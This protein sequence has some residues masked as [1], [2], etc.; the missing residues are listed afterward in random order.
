M[1]SQSE[2]DQLV[3]AAQA[4][5]VDAARAALAAGADP[6]GETQGNWMLVRRSVCH[7]AACELR[8]TTQEPSSVA[9]SG[10]LTVPH[11]RAVQSGRPAPLVAAEYGSLEVL[12]V[13]LD[14]GAKKDAKD[15]VR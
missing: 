12:K 6:N 5:N 1:A 14:H 13:L 8:A 11:V 15:G 3:A 4:N 9:R 2:T 10:P 7:W